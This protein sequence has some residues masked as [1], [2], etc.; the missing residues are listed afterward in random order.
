[1]NLDTY[2]KYVLYDQETSIYTAYTSISSAI[3]LSLAPT[4]TV[5]LV[6]TEIVPYKVPFLG[7]SPRK[8]CKTKSTEGTFCTILG[9]PPENFENQ[10][11]LRVLFVQR[12][13]VSRKNRKN[14]KYPHF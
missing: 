13:V 6:L 7:W 4:I 3:L 12:V 14:K 1:M 11:V 2:S 10:K 8:F 5:Y 9:G